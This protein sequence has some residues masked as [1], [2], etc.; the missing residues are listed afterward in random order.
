[1]EQLRSVFELIIIAII[2]R[3]KQWGIGTRRSC[4]APHPVSSL[5]PWS[6]TLLRDSS[7]ARKGR[8]G[9]LW[10]RWHRCPCRDD[11]WLHELIGLAWVQS[12]LLVWHAGIWQGSEGL[13]TFL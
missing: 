6:A 1:L 5:H 8:L 11:D 9:C 2:T 7:A 10:L 12:A 4:T 3:R 13:L